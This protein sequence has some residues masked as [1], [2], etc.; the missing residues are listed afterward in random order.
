MTLIGQLI[1][2]PHY[3]LIMSAVLRKTRTI[4]VFS[5]SFQIG[6]ADLSALYPTAYLMEHSCVPNTRHTFGPSAVTDMD[7]SFK[8]TVRASVDIKK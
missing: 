1:I 8:I 2:D 5:A 3:S 7:A 4:F 6:S